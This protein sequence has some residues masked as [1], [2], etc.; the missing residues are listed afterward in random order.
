MS[1]IENDIIEFEKSFDRLKKEAILVL[2]K[3]NSIRPISGYDFMEVDTID[4]ESVEFE[5]YETWAYGGHETYY[6]SFDPAIMYDEAKFEMYA[7]ELRKK[8]EKDILAKKE[9]NRVYKL[10]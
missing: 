2:E 8:N 6:Y 1:I 7:K 4:S 3:I 5:G 10:L 9:R